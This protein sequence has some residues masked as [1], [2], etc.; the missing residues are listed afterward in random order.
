M[1]VIWASEL[2]PTTFRDHRD[3]KQYAG[4]YQL[5]VLLYEAADKLPTRNIQG[6]DLPLQQPVAT[7]RARAGAG[8][9]L[10]VEPP[11]TMPIGAVTIPAETLAS[12]P[13]TGRVR[14]RWRF[15]PEAEL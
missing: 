10:S 15:L 2:A 5:E 3:G 12:L 14:I 4:K 1:R 9:P 11:D 7:V 6:R 13:L 8:Q